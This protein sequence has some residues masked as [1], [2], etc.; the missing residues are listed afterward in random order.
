MSWFLLTVAIMPEVAVPSCLMASL[1]C[2]LSS[3]S[4]SSTHSA[5]PPMPMLCLR[6]QCQHCI[7]HRVRSGKIIDHDHRF[8]LVWGTGH[9]F[10]DVEHCPDPDRGRRIEF[11][12]QDSLNDE[13]EQDEIW[14][15][16]PRHHSNII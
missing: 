6:N 7:C 4:S 15:D 5:S 12:E 16:D 8:Y 10:E 1:A 14:I 3:S 11:T 2:N 13:P 9:R